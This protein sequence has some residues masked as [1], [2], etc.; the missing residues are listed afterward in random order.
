MQLFGI[1]IFITKTDLDMTSIIEE[2]YKIK[3][4]DS[5]RLV[6]NIGG[7]QSSDDDYHTREEFK[8]L[9]DEINQALKMYRSDAEIYQSWINVNGKGD[10]NNIHDHEGCY[11]SGC[12]YLQVP[13]HSG[14]LVF[15]N[16]M[17]TKYLLNDKQK[18]IEPEDG[19]IIFFPDWLLHSVTENFSNDNR[20]SIAF[21]ILKR[22]ELK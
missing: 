7:W 9:F 17:L 10:L 5:G 8:P 19:M 11:L 1:P 6:S 16:P 12:V 14:R 2:I 15:H 18:D 22:G 13:E 3:E 21:N 4:T 20:I